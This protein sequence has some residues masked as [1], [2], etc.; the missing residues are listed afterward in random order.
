MIGFKT[1]TLL[2]QNTTEEGITYGNLLEVRAFG[3]RAFQA[4]SWQTLSA[5]PPTS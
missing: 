2:T 1:H 4:V 5:L 3:G